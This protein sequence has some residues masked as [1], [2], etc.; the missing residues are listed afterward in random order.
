MTRSH[1]RSELIENDLIFILSIDFAGRIWRWSSEPIELFDLNG[2]SYQFDGGLDGLELEEVLPFFGNSPDLLSASFDLLFPDDV[3]ELIN[4]GHDLSSA[5]GELASI[6]RGKAF[7]DRSILISGLVSHP[8]YGDKDEPVSF[9]LEEHPYSDR[10]LIPDVAASISADTGNNI[11]NNDGEV[12]PL[13]FG[14]AFQYRT[15]DGTL[16][17]LRMSPAIR[18]AQVGSDVTRL[19]VA[20]HKVPSST[21]EVTIAT[22]IDD[23]WYAGTADVFTVTDGLGRTISEAE[24]VA[25]HATIHA[26]FREQTSYWVRWTDGGALPDDMSTNEISGAGQLISWMLRRSSLRFDYA[27]W[28]AIQSHLDLYKVSGYINDQVSPFEWCE[29][30]VF[31]LLPITV[32]SGES[33]LFP[34]LWRYWATAADSIADIVATAGIVR[35]GRVQY[36]QSPSETYQKISLLWAY[37][38]GDGEH[39]RTLTVRPSGNV[40]RAADEIFNLHSETSKSR[41]QNENE[42]IEESDIIY[43]TA[44]AERVLGWWSLAKGFTHRVVSYEVD[45]HFSWLKIGDV[46]SISDSGIH[47]NSEI[48]LIRSIVRSDT[49][50]IV[51]SLQLIEDLA[52]AEYS[53]GES[54]PLVDGNT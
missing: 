45:Q 20:G 33:G 11:W 12:Y 30:N 52:A 2:S 39:R 22:K 40:A 29:Q 36:D 23:S 50:R 37:D 6:A 5:S 16:E 3:S 44:T 41:Y 31:P 43:D 42:L 19:I 1:Y 34:V 32:H 15:T 17:Q 13:P 53:T 48:A 7:E 8:E 35:V 14:A 28:S 26:K 54:T 47:L 51:L 4:F 46:V 27:A 49:G 38:D 25:S 21:A 10:A 24:L 18:S 9:T